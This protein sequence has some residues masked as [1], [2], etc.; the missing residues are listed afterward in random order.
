MADGTLKLD[1]GA[2][3]E[4]GRANRAVVALLSAVLGVR[5]SAARVVRGERSRGK[6][7]EVDGLDDREARSRITAALAGERTGLP[8]PG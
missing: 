8:G 4:D 2:P 3:P 5:E 1:V 7:V 6:L